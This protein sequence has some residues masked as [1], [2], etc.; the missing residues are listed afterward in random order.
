MPYT[1]SRG[2][3]TARLL[4]AEKDFDETSRLLDTIAE[5]FEIEFIDMTEIPEYAEYVKS[6]QYSEWLRKH[7][8]P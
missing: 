2:A 7:D 6:P 3:T 8:E 4:S 5:N 1:T